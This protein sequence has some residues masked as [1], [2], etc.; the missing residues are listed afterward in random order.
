MAIAEKVI[1]EHIVGEEAFSNHW[2][3]LRENLES[4]VRTHLQECFA[5]E[6]FYVIC[7]KFGFK[8]NFSLWTTKDRENVI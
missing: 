3:L 2:L 6:Q 7:G 1:R 8:G 4:F 5:A